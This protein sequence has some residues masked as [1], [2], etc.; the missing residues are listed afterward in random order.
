MALGGL[1]V[2]FLKTREKWNSSQKPSAAAVS[3]TESLLFSNSVHPSLHQMTLPD[4]DHRPTLEQ[5]LLS[6]TRIETFS[7]QPIKLSLF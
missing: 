2:I 7:L 6:R 3:F 1:P 5:K 4:R